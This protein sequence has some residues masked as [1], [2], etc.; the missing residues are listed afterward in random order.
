MKRVFVS[1]VLLGL[2]GLVC[3]CGSGPQLE[4]MAKRLYADVDMRK[5]VCAKDL[6]SIDE[7]KIGV[8]FHR[9]DERYHKNKIVV[10]IVEPVLSAANSYAGIFVNKGGDFE[11]QFISYG[12]GVKVGVNGAGIPMIFEYGFGD[13]DNPDNVVNQYLWNG[14]SFV[15]IRS[16]KLAH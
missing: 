3:A 15:F 14:E 10:C 8:K 7:F 11:L 5:F 1:A 4:N 6:C 9:Y 13:P 2:S 12:T 16:V